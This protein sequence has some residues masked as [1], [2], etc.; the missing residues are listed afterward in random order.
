M[1]SVTAI[2]IQGSNQRS[3]NGR[4]EN[5]KGTD[6]TGR[7]TAPL[8]CGEGTTGGPNQPQ[9]LQPIPASAAGAAGCSFGDCFLERFLEHLP[10]RFWGRGGS[11]SK[12][13]LSYSQHGRHMANNFG[14]VDAGDIEAVD[15]N[16]RTNDN[17]RAGRGEQELVNRSRPRE[18]SESGGPSSV[19]VAAPCF[20]TPTPP[21]NLCAAVTAERWR[22]YH[23]YHAWMGT[24]DDCEQRGRRRGAHLPLSE[25]GHAE[26][27]RPPSLVTAWPAADVQI[28]LGGESR[29]QRVGA[30][31]PGG[32]VSR[33]YALRPGGTK[34]QG[35]KQ[36]GRRALNHTAGRAEAA[37]SHGAT[38]EGRQRQNGRRRADRS[39]VVAA[40]RRAGRSAPHLRDCL[41]PPLY[42]YIY[43]YIC[44]AAD[45]Q[46]SMAPS[47]AA[48]RSRPTRHLMA[49]TR[50][51]RAT[52]RTVRRRTSPR[53]PP[54][55]MAQRGRDADRLGRRIRA[56]CRESCA[57]AGPGL[58]HKLS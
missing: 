55:D 41:A 3:P 4:G 8:F 58:R 17:S 54:S 42:I 57:G 32:R 50:G 46:S 28:V 19:T 6:L 47:S 23:I 26:M 36:S 53:T 10:E 15:D 7:F 48:T 34:L 44:D 18:T 35:S 37:H 13:T 31:A 40:A 43:A 20:L 30:L 24:L 27:R 1:P 21:R 56:A 52:G 14:G 9:A 16:L 11:S 51:G 49:A 12:V 22:L 33:Y 2:V 25:Q 29:T 39:R 5:K 45:G 38:P